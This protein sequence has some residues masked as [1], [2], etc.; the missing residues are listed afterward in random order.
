[1]YTIDSNVPMP[2][3]RSAKPIT[4]Q[5]LVVGTMDKLKK[6][7]SFE[8]PGNAKQLSQYQAMFHKKRKRKR[9][10]VRAI[11]KSKARVWRI[12]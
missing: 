2:S 1:M 8:Y 6:G 9:L 11:G 10:T 7:Q 5:D 4:K 12:K 3:G